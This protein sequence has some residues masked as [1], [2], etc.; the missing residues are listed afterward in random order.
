MCGCFKNVNEKLAEYNGQLEFNMLAAEPRAMISLCKVA[1]ASR[2]KPPLME[3]S[4]CPFCGKKYPKPKRE[5]FE[6]ALARASAE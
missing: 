5:S 4:Y 2:R 6:A 1:S 3:A